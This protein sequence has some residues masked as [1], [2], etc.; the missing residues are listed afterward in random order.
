MVDL[1]RSQFFD[2]T[3]IERWTLYA[4]YIQAGLSEDKSKEVLQLPL[5]PP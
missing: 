2:K 5:V 3:P 1:R 4:P